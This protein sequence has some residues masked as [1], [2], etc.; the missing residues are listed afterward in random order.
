MVNDRHSKESGIVLVPDSVRQ[1]G[2]YELDL[3]KF[4]YFGW[5][6][7][8]TLGLNFWQQQFLPLEE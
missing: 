3:L 5:L 7:G 4:C 1:L 2:G 6:N 8:L